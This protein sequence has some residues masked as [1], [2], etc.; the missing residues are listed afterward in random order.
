[1][2]VEILG[3]GCAKCQLLYEKVSTLA[4]RHGIQ[5][6]L[7]KVTEMEQILD[8]GV[9]VTPALV[10]DGVVKSSGRIPADRDILA[11]LGS[12]SA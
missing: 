12:R 2:K 6:E 9:M 4:G 7:S 8:Y 10:I 11:W 3:S 5:I 1:M